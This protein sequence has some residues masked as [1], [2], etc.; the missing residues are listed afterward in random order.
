MPWRRIRRRASAGE[1]VSTT[2]SA[3]I[4]IDGTGTETGTAAQYGMRLKGILDDVNATLTGSALISYIG[5]RHHTIRVVPL[6][7]DP[8]GP[9][10][11]YGVYARPDDDED[12][13]VRGARLRQ[14]DG[15]NFGRAFGTRSTLRCSGCTPT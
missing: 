1:P 12:A 14:F 10:P 5:L 6:A 7:A 11:T 8:A 3:N 2:Y 9:Q 15:S 13:F 4:D